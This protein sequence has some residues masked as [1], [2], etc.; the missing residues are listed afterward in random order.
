MKR[1]SDL[2][3]LPT[4]EKDLYDGMGMHSKTPWTSD[5][6][7]DEFTGPRPDR[8]EGEADMSVPTEA[9]LL[10]ALY[11][12]NGKVRRTGK[13]SGPNLLKA[14]RENPFVRHREDTR[15]GVPEADYV[16]GHS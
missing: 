2:N 3:L 13:T 6:Y 9:G 10:P 8:R 15:Q 14:E 11:D 1:P 4:E 16:H 5:E 7:R 12:Y